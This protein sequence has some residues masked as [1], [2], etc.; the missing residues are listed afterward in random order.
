M[1]IVATSRDFEHCED[2]NVT[3]LEVEICESIILAC[4]TVKDTHLFSLIKCLVPCS[5]SYAILC[6]QCS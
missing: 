3:D 1:E 4:H 5:N 2:Y 6:L